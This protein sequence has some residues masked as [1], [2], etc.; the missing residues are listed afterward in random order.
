MSRD[1]VY[2]SRDGE[3]FHKVGRFLN[4]DDARVE[5]NPMSDTYDVHANLFVHFTDN[6][7]QDT[8]RMLHCGT[9]TVDT[10]KEP[11]EPHPT[12]VQVTD[13]RGN[14]STYEGVG[15]TAKKDPAGDLCIRDAAGN[16]VATHLH[17]HYSMF[18]TFPGDTASEKAAREAREFEKQK[19]R[20]K[21]LAGMS[22]DYWQI[23][24]PPTVGAP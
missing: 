20:L 1:Y 19:E 9:P 11:E 14:V 15:H 23:T 3:T 13:T 22:G 2:L 24:E 10:T 8:R 6:A 17:G 12:V 5:R 7:D 4:V 18:T 16:H 21:L